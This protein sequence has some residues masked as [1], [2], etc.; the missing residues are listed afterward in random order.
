MENIVAAAAITTPS[1]NNEGGEVEQQSRLWVYLDAVLCLSLL[2]DS[3]RTSFDRSLLLPDNGG[4]GDSLVESVRTIWTRKLNHLEKNSSVTTFLQYF[5]DFYFFVR[6]FN[7]RE[8]FTHLVHLSSELAASTKDFTYL[9]YFN[10]FA[11]IVD[12]RDY[13]ASIAGDDEQHSSVSK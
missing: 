3:A 2:S 10:T 9:S 11:S 12:L 1:P 4:S 13:A 7:T 6:S 8:F 5:Q